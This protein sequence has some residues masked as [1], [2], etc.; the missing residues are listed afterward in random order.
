MQRHH[1]VIRRIWSRLVCVGPPNPPG[2]EPYDEEDDGTSSAATSEIKSLVRSLRRRIKQEDGY[3]PK[4]S[5]GS[6]KVEEFYGD[7]SRYSKWKRAIEAQQHLY[8]LKNT[9]LAMLVYLSTCREA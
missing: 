5:L 8:S 7:R 1:P 3:R 6:V 9:E 4:C 2:S